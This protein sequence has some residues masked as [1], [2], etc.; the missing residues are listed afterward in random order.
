MTRHLWLKRVVSAVLLAVFLTTVLP[1]REVSA[2]VQ[3]ASG[4]YNFVAGTGSWTLRGIRVRLQWFQHDEALAIEASGSNKDYANAYAAAMKSKVNTYYHSNYPDGSTAVYFLDSNNTYGRPNPRPGAN[5]G[6]TY[7]ASATRNNLFVIPPDKYYTYSGSDSGTTYSAGVNVLYERLKVGGPDHQKLLDWFN[8]KDTAS[9]KTYAAAYKTQLSNQ[10]KAICSAGASPTSKI[11][12]AFMAWSQMKENPTYASDEEALN[13]SIAY[14]CAVMAV[15]AIEDDVARQIDGAAIDVMISNPASRATQPAVIAF[16][17]LAC[18]RQGSKYVWYGV[19]EFY[20]HSVGIPAERFKRAGLEYG[21]TAS[22]TKDM[23]IKVFGAKA[24]QQMSWKV[25]SVF[26]GLYSNWK[27]IPSNAQLSHQL[28]FIAGGAESGYT[29]F[30]IAGAGPAQVGSLLVPQTPGTFSLTATPK[31]KEIYSPSDETPIISIDTTNTGD[32]LQKLKDYLGKCTSWEVT[33]HLERDGTTITP[34]GTKPLDTP[35]QM[36]SAE[37][38]K[39]IDG[40]N[41]KLEYIDQITVTGN[42]GDTIQY[43]YKATIHFK[44]N[45]TATGVKE[46]NLKGNPDND[47]VSY[48]PQPE[49]PIKYQSA[50][51]GNYSEIK[52]NDI[53]EEDYEAMA[54]VPTTENLYFASGGSEFLVQLTAE[55]KEQMVPTARTYNVTYKSPGPCSHTAQSRSH[56]L[57]KENAASGGTCSHTEDI[58]GTGGTVTIAFTGPTQGEATEYRDTKDG[59]V[60]IKWNWYHDWPGHTCTPSDTFTWTQE[61]DPI[62]YVSIIDVKVWKLSEARVDGTRELLDTDEIKADIISTPTD[63]AWNVAKQDSAAAGRLY[64]SYASN[65][66]STV[67]AYH[68]QDTVNI[69]LVGSNNHFTHSTDNATSFN[70]WVANQKNK[71]TVVSDYLILRTSAGDQ[72]IVYYEYDS[73]EHTIASTATATNNVSSSGKNKNDVTTNGTWDVKADPLTFATLPTLQQVWD[74]NKESAKGANFTDTSITWGG[75]HGNYQATSTKY[76]STH[77]PINMTRFDQLT[78]NKAGYAKKRTIPKPSPIFRLEERD[79]DIPDTKE[80]QAYIIGNAEVWYKLIVNDG[81]KPEAEG[82]YEMATNPNF[83]GKGQVFPSV[84]APGKNKIN[85]IIVFDPV[86]VQGAMALSPPPEYDQ[87]TNGDTG[88][89]ADLNNGNAECPGTAENCNYSVLN[90]SWTG[91]HYHTSD[92]F[93]QVVTVREPQLIYNTHVHNEYCYEGESCAGQPCMETGRHVSSRCPYGHSC[94]GCNPCHSDGAATLVCNNK[95][96]NAFDPDLVALGTGFSWGGSNSWPS[97]FDSYLVNNIVTKSVYRDVT[98]PSYSGTLPTAGCDMLEVVYRVPTEASG[99]SFELYFRQEGESTYYERGGV[100]RSGV[101]ATGE[102]ETLTISI[103]NNSDAYE[104]KLNK[105]ITWLRCDFLN[106][107]SVNTTGEIKSIRMYS[108]GNGMDSTTYQYVGNNYQN[109]S[110]DAGT[111]LLTAAGGSGGAGYVSG[112]DGAV[113][114]GMVTF[115]APTTLKLEVGDSGADG[116]SWT[117]GAPQDSYGGWGGSRSSIIIGN[118]PILVAGGGGGGGHHR[119]GY[120]GGRGSQIGDTMSKGQNANSHGGG[121]GSGYKGGYGGSCQSAAGGGSN[122][123]SG[124]VSEFKVTGYNTGDGYITITKVSQGE[125]ARVITRILTCTEPHHTFST[126]WHHYTEGWLH[127]DGS[128]CTAENCA[129]CKAGVKLKFPGGSDYVAISDITK[130]AYLVNYNNEM[131]LTYGTDSAIEYYSPARELHLPAEDFVKATE[132]ENLIGSYTHYPFGDEICYDA[133][134]NDLNHKPSTSATKPDGT[135]V[136]MGTFLNLDMGFTLYYP[137]VGDFYGNG[138]FGIGNLQLGITGKG[139]ED[140]MDTTRWT[141]EKTVQFPF[142]VIFNGTMYLANTEISL[143]VAQTEFEFYLPLENLEVADARIFYNAYA[144][145]QGTVNNPEQTNFEVVNKNTA[146]RYEHAW[147]QQHI[148]VVGRI[149]NLVIEDT[150][151]WRFSNLFK[152]TTTGWYV[153]NLVKNTIENKQN[154][155]VADLFDVRNNPVS[156]LTQFL[157]TWGLLPHMQQ[158]PI[159]LPLTP[160]KNNIVG[161]QKQPMRMGYNLYMDVTTYGNYYGETYDHNDSGAWVNDPSGIYKMQITPYYYFLNLDTGKWTQLDMYIEDSGAYKAINLHGN[162]TNNVAYDFDLALNWRD[163]QGR[164]NVVQAEVDAAAAINNEYGP[165]LHPSGSYYSL[166]NAQRLFLREK[167]RTFIGTSET[168]GQDMNPGDK[169]EEIKYTRQG[170]RWH[171]TVGLPSS[172]VYVEKGK[173]CVETNIQALQ[174]QNGVVV[175]ALEILVKGDTWTL[176]YDGSSINT[177][178]KVTPTSP[179]YDPNDPNGPGPGKPI[180]TIYHPDKTSKDDLAIFGTH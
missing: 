107:S 79:I 147:K 154:N 180:I 125:P 80:N 6:T 111:Y 171:F 112:G 163:E 23:L 4:S 66:T 15:W 140:N 11:P 156:V 139:Y 141:K 118:S 95:P 126:N 69:T 179:E 71:V 121:G 136:Q 99:V 78:I 103:P 19:P 157:N 90:C 25:I 64:Y 45:C 168:Y 16:E 29:N 24:K 176:K 40:T 86:S 161:L 83:S 2:L 117:G 106:N 173:P 104:Y 28:D 151:D 43:N 91:N 124:I 96:L 31:G 5:Q 127:E 76:N 34:A 144:I 38:I 41:S 27:Y 101:R 123:S 14:F 162:T 120:D 8:N 53:Y 10:F 138:A 62:D 68:G 94:N 92:C 169:I 56:E 142:D 132:T 58:T 84:Y 167:A 35:I 146:E 18:I 55:F 65:G 137:N 153:P 152:Q 36:P 87:R 32:E 178:F 73:N 158:Q 3:F 60:P 97:V 54:G 114:R 61:I 63:A 70:A 160:A 57:C 82:I 134:H 1:T 149:G 17:D 51:Q 131:I 150:G 98:Y 89:I 30:F 109:I 102:W 110:V 37:A 52:H 93:T 50:L 85:D 159:S 119:S 42:P 72:S 49:P 129:K 22:N 148:D 116:N 33:I 21:I 67:D 48:V 113:V 77:G 128:E 9:W 155:I 47:F 177:P 108:S 166:G 115:D 164:R 39:F 122:F 20:A 172:T 26:N 44:P 133:C 46:F 135:N 7:A 145:N 130:N 100:I 75:Y 174:K 13:D 74:T 12:N 105:N 81:T 143:P 59:Q 170:Q 88:I 175:C 165:L